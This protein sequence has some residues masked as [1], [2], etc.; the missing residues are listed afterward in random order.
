VGGRGA[1]IRPPESERLPLE[2]LVRGYTLSG[3]YQL[4]MEAKLGSVE[5]GKLADLV[6][7]DKN[8]FDVDR[9]DI[10]TLSP[11]A[12]LLEGKVVSGRLP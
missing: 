7:L 6:V 2:D 12:V 3:A 10:S 5:I 9:Y 1:A 11:S 8:L 4:R